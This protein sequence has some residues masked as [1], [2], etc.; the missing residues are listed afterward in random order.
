MLSAIFEANVIVFS[1]YQLQADVVPLLLGIKP[2]VEAWEILGFPGPAPVLGKSCEPESLRE[3][4]WVPVPPP[5]GNHSLAWIHGWSWAGVSCPTRRGSRTSLAISVDPGS[6]VASCPF[7]RSRELI[8]LSPV[9]AAAELCLCPGNRKA[10]CLSSKADV[11]FLT[12][13]LN[14][15]V[16]SGPWELKS[17]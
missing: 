15:E 16:L 5:R 2:G 3:T 9:F 7:P 10:T 14:N 4:F 13:F 1:L 8:P 11:V 12:F 17:C 6:N